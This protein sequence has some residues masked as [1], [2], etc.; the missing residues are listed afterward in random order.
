MLKLFWNLTFLISG[1]I[2]ISHTNEAER[3]AKQTPLTFIMLPVN[4]DFEPLAPGSTAEMIELGAWEEVLNRTM[5]D[6]TRSY[7]P[8]TYRTGKA[9]KQPVYPGGDIHPKWGVCADITV[10]SLRKAGFDLQKMIHEDI[11]FDKS[12]YEL[13]RR[14]GQAHPDPNIDH[15][16]VDNQLIFLQRYA[17]NLTTKVDSTTLAEW[18]PGDIVIWDEDPDDARVD[19]VGIISHR[20]FNRNGLP[21]VINNNGRTRLVDCLDRWAIVGHFRWHDPGDDLL[22]NTTEDVIEDCEY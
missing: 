8:L 22:V 18:Q 13:K 5:Y 4:I 2:V 1:L 12:A 3:I 20:Q 17:Q 11:K 14:Y 19:H 9:M 21:Y 6:T 10:R 16:R 7:R 15:R